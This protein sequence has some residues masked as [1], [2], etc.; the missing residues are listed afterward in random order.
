MSNLHR[1]SW[2]P[3]F[4]PHGSGSGVNLQK[5]TKI[6]C[7]YQHMKVMS[8]NTTTP[9]VV[10]WDGDNLQKK[11]FCPEMSDMFSPKKSQ[12]CQPS[13]PMGWW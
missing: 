9:Y 2:L 4:S 1:K 7:P 5:I 13:V 3:I 11:F 12:S 8:S 10:G 6:E